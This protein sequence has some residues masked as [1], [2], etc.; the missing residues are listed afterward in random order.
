MFRRVPIDG[1][2]TEMTQGRNRIGSTDLFSGNYRRQ[3]KGFLARC[4]RHGSDL[5]P[6]SLSFAGKGVFA[7][8]NAE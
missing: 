1:W 6:C 3:E 5:A 2:Q 7:A 8:F 4:A